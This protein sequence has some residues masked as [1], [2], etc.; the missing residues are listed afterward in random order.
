MSKKEKIPSK[1]IALFSSG[2]AGAALCSLL[3]VTIAMLA[4]DAP[5]TKQIICVTSPVALAFAIGGL[6]VA[7]I[8]FY[9]PG[10]TKEGFAGLILSIA[11]IITA[12]L[13]SYFVG[14][15]PFA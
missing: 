8:S 1:E 9:K 6:I 7:I 4:V 11:T 10:I 2:L 15:F 12:L 13:I 14:C 5:D 3:G